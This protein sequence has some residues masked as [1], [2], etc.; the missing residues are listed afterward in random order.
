MKKLF[1][2]IIIGL[3]LLLPTKADAVAY[4][5][6]GVTSEEKELVVA[7]EVEKKNFFEEIEYRML[8]KDEDYD[9]AD[10]AILAIIV[11]L[12]GIVIVELNRKTYVVVKG[13]VFEEP[14][15][16]DNVSTFEVQ[17]NDNSENNVENTEE[18]SND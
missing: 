12:I 11:I 14:K 18:V 10:Y 3:I 5:S 7:Q 6:Y 2:L 4:H 9:S 15:V 8:Y 16:N 17:N 13:T 1:I